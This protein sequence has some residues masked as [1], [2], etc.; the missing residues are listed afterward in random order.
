MS[1]NVR[2]HRNREQVQVVISCNDSR[3]VIIWPQGMLLWLQKPTHYDTAETEERGTRKTTDKY[4]LHTRNAR[5][6]HFDTHR[7][8]S[9]PTGFGFLLIPVQ[10][11]YLKWRFWDEERGCAK[12]RKLFLGKRSIIRTYLF[13]VT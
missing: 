8:V 5:G 12:L 7:Y 13:V 11:T 9:L 10:R 6:A 2:E 3:G 4:A 1:E